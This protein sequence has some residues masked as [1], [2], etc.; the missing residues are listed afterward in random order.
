MA[1]TKH[2]IILM[3]EAGFG[4]RSAARAIADALQEL[5]GETCW[6]EILNPLNDR[7]S[8]A[9]LRTMQTDYDK[10]VQQRPDLYRRSYALS[11]A[12]V[13]TA[14]MDGVLTVGLFDALRDAV[15]SHWPD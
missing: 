8:P 11:D 9:L 7:R 12:S 1:E 5:Y 14:L 4:H 2:I 10:V 3:T 6:V 13:P 15:Q